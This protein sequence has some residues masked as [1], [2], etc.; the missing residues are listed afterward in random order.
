MHTTSLHCE[1]HNDASHSDVDPDD[2]YVSYSELSIPGN[3]QGH[4][5]EVFI[6]V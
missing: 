5:Y 6:K 1:L 3:E 2:E 4:D